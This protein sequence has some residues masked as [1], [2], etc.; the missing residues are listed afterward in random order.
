M[1]RIAF[2]GQDFIGD[3]LVWAN[4]LEAVGRFFAPCE[5]TVFCPM[6]RVELYECMVFC[7]QVLGYDPSMMWSA[8]EARGFGHF[9]IVLNTRY[10]ADSISR[11]QALDH[12]SAYGFENID[13]PE[14]VCKRVYTDYVPLSRWDDFHLRRETSI[15]EQGAELIRIFDPN[16]HCEMIRFDT[17]TFKREQAEPSKEPMAI[18]AMGASDPTKRWALKNYLEVARFLRESDVSPLFLLGPNELEFESDIGIAGFQIRKCL[19]FKK[20]AGF[21]DKGSGT[22]CV[23]GND[24]GLMHLACAMGV[25][26]VTIMP[27]GTHF[28]WFPYAADNRAEHI[29]ITPECADIMCVNECRQRLS[30]VGKISVEEVKRA[31]S[32]LISREYGFHALDSAFSALPFSTGDCP[33]PRRILHLNK[34]AIP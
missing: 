3:A 4:M 7:N 25:P 32:G 33:T 17:S 27:H 28:T 26:S 9:D 13:I 19:S 24:T 23:L 12:D 11:I 14:P 16:Y 18:F 31:V 29:C 20:I 2:F 15:T 21:F 1:K 6:D 30:C 10:D 34:E 8:E 22:V 5:V